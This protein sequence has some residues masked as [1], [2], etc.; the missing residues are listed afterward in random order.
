MKTLTLRLK[1]LGLPLTLAASLCLS[2]MAH[3]TAEHEVDELTEQIRKH[4]ESE[5]LLVQRAIEYRLLGKN[6]EAV[7]DLK[8]ALKLKPLSTPAHRELSRAYTALGKGGEAFKT[9]NRGL[10]AARDAAERSTLLVLRAEMHRAAN[11]L[12]EALDDVQTAIAG[13][14]G[15]VDWYLLRSDV[16]GLL[17]RHEQRIAGLEEAIRET[18]SGLL[19]GEMVDAFIDAGRHAAALAKIEPELK[20]ARLRST[21]LVR[22]ARVYLATGKRAEGRSDLTAAVAELNR[23]INPLAPDPSLLADRG[24]AHELLGDQESACKDYE[25]A[26]AKGHADEWLAEHLRALKAQAKKKPGK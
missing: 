9:V 1:F 5:D 10:A 6:E 14:P 17:K 22:R 3:E 7:A 11:G 2:A 16:Q 19:D 26:R 23:R 13:F 15:N 21:W 20:S 4:G 24:L 25:L 12:K 18:G 8:R